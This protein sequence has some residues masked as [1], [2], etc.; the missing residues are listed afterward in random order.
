TASGTCTESQ[1]DDTTF[2]QAQYEAVTDKIHAGMADLSNLIREII[3][4][5]ETGTDH[6]YIPGFVKDAVIWLAK[7]A[8]DIAESL[9]HKFTELLKGVMAPIS[10]FASAYHWTH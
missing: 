6:W 8:V 7:E 4:A 2:S 9:W 3:P 10:F 1:G 5:A